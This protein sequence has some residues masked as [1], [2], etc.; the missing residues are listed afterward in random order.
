[1]KSID[2]KMCVCL[3]VFSLVASLGLGLFW[4]QIGVAHWLHSLDLYEYD[5]AVSVVMLLSLSCTPI[6][7]IAFLILWVALETLIAVKRLLPKKED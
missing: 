5:W 4:C 1:M 2:K 7:Y 3:F 6:F